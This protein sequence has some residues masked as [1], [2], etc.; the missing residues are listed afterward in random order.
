MTYLI[1]IE[2]ELLKDIDP[3]KEA[4]TMIDFIMDHLDCPYES[5]VNLTVTDNETIREYNR[6]Y[7][8]IDKATDV[9]SFPMV[10]YEQPFDFSLAEQSPDVY[11]NPESGELLL[12]D[13]VI[14]AE[15]VIEQ[16]NEY[17]HSIK[18]EFCFLITHSMLHLF[19]YDHIEE[20]DRFEME[21]LQEEIMNAAGIGR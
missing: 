4:K 11:F 17:G 12:G 21:R 10:D 2:N 9:L 3:E 14:S 8:N 18:R 15:K 16:A 19:G 7:R 6:G 20:E 1:Q 5:E 13:I